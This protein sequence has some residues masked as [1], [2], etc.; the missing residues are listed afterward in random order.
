MADVKLLASQRLTDNPDGGGLMTSIEVVDGVVNNLWPD[1]SR[2]DRVYGVVNLRKLFV[3]ADTPDTAIYSGLHVILLMP[4]Q[5]PRVT[6]TMFTTNNWSDVRAD[7]QSALERYLDMSVVTRLIPFDRQLAGQR[8]I[9]GFQRPELDLP[10]IGEVYVITKLPDETIVQFVR[11]KDLHHEIQTF[12]DPDSGLDFKAR[13]VTLTL[14]EPLQ[15]TFQGSQPTK[16]F[17]AQVNTS[18]LRRTVVSDAVNYHTVHALAADAAIGD[19]TIKLDSIF[20]QLVPAST[21][22]SALVDMNPTGVLTLVAASNTATLETIG[23]PPTFFLSRA[24]MPGSLSID[25]GAGRFYYDDGAGALREGSSSGPSV[26]TVTYADARVDWTSPG[27]IITMDVR[28]IPAAVI[29]K[30]AQTAQ[31]PIT[32]STRGY[33]Y[34]ETLHPLPMPGNLKVSFRAVG[35]WYDLDDDGSG[36]VLGDA[37]LGTGALNFATGTVSTSLGAL[38]DIGSS[39]I[40][41]WGGNGEFEI[42]TADI[43]IS[44]PVVSATLTGGNVEPSTLTVTWYANAV[45]KTATDDGTGGLTGDATGRVIYGSGEVTIKPILLPDPS[46]T[47]SFAYQKAAIHTELFNPSLSG[48]TI[49]MTVAHGPVRP[50]SILVTFQRSFSTLYFG[51]IWNTTVQLVDDGTGGL[52][53]LDGTPLSG[54]AVNYT[55][56]QISF[57]PNGVISTPTISYSQFDNAVPQRTVDPGTGYH[58][59]KSRPG[60]WPS[61]VSPYDHVSEF[62]NGSNVTIAYKEDGATDSAATYSV[63]TPPLSIDLTPTVSSPIVPGGVEFTLGGRTYIDRAGSLYYNVSF[64]TNAATLGGSIDYQTGQ[65]TITSWVG[66]GSNTLAFRALLTQVDQMPVFVLN[67]RTPG[68]PLRP[69]SFY[70]QATTLDGTLISATA[71]TDGNITTSNM[72]G[73]VDVTTGVFSIAFGH[74][75]LDSSLTSDE[76]AQP[77][78]DS[79]NVDADGY[80]LVPDPVIPN[81]IT[82]N[83]VVQVAT[84][85]DSVILGLDP[86]RLPLDGRVQAVR[87]G[88]MIIFHDSQ[89]TT[90][91]SGLTAGQVVTLP[92]D[93]LALVEVR[94][95]TGALVPGEF[96]GGPTVSGSLYTADLAAGTITMQTPLDLSAY[97]QPLV[98]THRIEDASLVSDVQ[99]TGHVTISE[100]LTHAYT[101]SNSLAS[102]ALIAPF[103]GGSVQAAYNHLFTQQTWDN[104]H[105]NWTDAV[106]GSGTT[107]AVDDLNFPIQVLNRD[108]ITE[109][110]AF[111]VRGGGT[112]VDV[113]GQD[114]GVII[115]NAPMSANIAPVNPGTGNPYFVFDY[116]AFGAGWNDGN[117]IRFDTQGAGFPPWLARTIKSGPATYTDDRNV[118]EA[119]WDKS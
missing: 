78:Y 39:I 29:S 100:P 13:V 118:V 9:L 94:D 54:S 113:V 18:K 1:I 57:A 81:T 35:R 83:A 108:A 52:N 77:W 119:R 72:H 36:A 22:E 24:I 38:P 43:T 66:G 45:L 117:A 61:Q 75:A 88:Y 56:G 95:Q 102:T 104:A 58:S 64:S 97:T 92:R 63:A 85:L 103:V 48:S 91:P 116:R 51:K 90:M 33:V 111:I 67:G 25:A 4:P 20:T 26:G 76:K 106:V 99:I 114:L 11:I 31:Q 8:T 65:A 69:A 40:Y 28:Y 10:N 53:F 12:T 68:S 73:Y 6:V 50:K 89:V 49:T 110:W 105:P 107:A 44:T 23:A 70:I 74:Y 60:L 115:S 112:H 46:T 55:T 96:V 5:D 17:I 21:S 7:A 62:V 42:R 37:G 3:K 34:V 71:D 30:L 82:Y 80:Y 27:N 109:K 87:A 98:A 59:A 2:V 32:Q 79:D 14:T 101:A 47:F 16:Q 84:P 86:V 93:T 15:F 41:S 19:Q